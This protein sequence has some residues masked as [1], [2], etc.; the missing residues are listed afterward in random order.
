MV[1]TFF[2]GFKKEQFEKWLKKVVGQD[3]RY[4]HLLISEFEEERLDFYNYFSRGLSP[5]QALQKE[6]HE[7]G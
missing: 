1:G 5:W 4:K 7:Y 6:Y 3:K 2:E